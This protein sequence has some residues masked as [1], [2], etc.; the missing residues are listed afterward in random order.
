MFRVISNL[1]KIAEISQ[2]FMVIFSVIL[3]YRTIRLHHKF[4]S[5]GS[6]GGGLLTGRILFLSARRQVD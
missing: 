6:V 2:E 3:K 4:H 1:F 5:L